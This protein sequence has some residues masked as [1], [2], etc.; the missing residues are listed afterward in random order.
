MAAAYWETLR[1]TVG[2][3]E[4]IIAP[5]PLLGLAGIL[6]ECWRLDMSGHINSQGISRRKALLFGLSATL[7]FVAPATLLTSRD[8]EAQ[9]PEPQSPGTQAPGAPSPGMQAPGTQAPGAQTP[10]Q[11]RQGRRTTRAQ[12]RARRRQARAQRRAA[13]RQGRTQRRAIRRNGAPGTSTTGTGATGTAPTGT[14]NTGQA[15]AKQ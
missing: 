12:R 8:A 3:S 1:L 4:F 15:P 13:R 5:S 6:Q 14:G 10:T 2:K 9:T 7:A 11:R